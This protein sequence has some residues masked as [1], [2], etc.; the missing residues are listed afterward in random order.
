M[1][2]WTILVREKP[3]GDPNLVAVPSGFSLGA[4]L[5]Q[6]LWALYRKAWFTALV[7][8]SA[9]MLVPLAG[10]VVDLAPGAMVVLQIA[11]AVIMALG[12]NEIRI[13]ELHLRRYQTIA[14]LKARNLDEAEIRGF[15]HWLN[16]S[17]TVP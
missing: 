4:F 14:M 7:L 9:G 11:L 13:G 8:L 2:E 5:F 12:A 10:G 1:R 15:E 16:Q 3:S 6:A 17:E